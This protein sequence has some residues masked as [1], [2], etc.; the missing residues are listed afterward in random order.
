MRCLRCWNDQDGK[1]FFDD[2]ENLKRPEQK[3]SFS[4]SITESTI[5]AFKSQAS[6]A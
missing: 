2:L 4:G 5:T 1:W 6:E 3:E